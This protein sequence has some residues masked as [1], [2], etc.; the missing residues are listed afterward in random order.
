MLITEKQIMQLINIAH[1]HL[2]FLKSVHET[3][4]TLLTEEGLHNMTHIGAL[5]ENITAQQ[6]EEIKEIE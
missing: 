3:D 4:K 5:L 6:S 2:G 1:L